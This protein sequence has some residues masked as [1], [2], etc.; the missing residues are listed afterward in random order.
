[1]IFQSLHFPSPP[2]VSPRALHSP[3]HTTSRGLFKSRSDWG[4]AAN[5]LFV[6]LPVIFVCSFEQEAANDTSSLI[7][8]LR[9]RD[10]DGN[11]LIAGRELE[12]VGMRYAK[13]HRRSASITNKEFGEDS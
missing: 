2:H 6:G 1:M 13:K 3:S 9:S 11:V 10:L 7:K 5:N 8:N 12:T 4:E